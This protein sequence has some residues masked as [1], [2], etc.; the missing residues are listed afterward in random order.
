MKQLLNLTACAALLLAIT[1]LASHAQDV[2]R[3]ATDASIAR[4]LDAKG[5]P[6][7]V[8]DDGDY[9]ILVNVGEDRTQ[10][11]WVRSRVHSTDHQHVREIW[12]YGYR[13]DERRI[14]VHIANRLLSENFDLIVGAW[15]REN[16]NA[17]LV[18]KIDAD[19]DAEALNEA[20]DLAASVGDRMEQKLVT[21]DDL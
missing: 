7:T 17:I 15:A 4:K 21:G 2:E 8:D 16:G 14:P 9:R 3:G 6:Y 11:V 13:S 18:M 12:T 20:I 1:P 19:A 5:T 10:L